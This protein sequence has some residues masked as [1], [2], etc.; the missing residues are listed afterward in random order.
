MCEPIDVSAPVVVAKNEE[1]RSDP[2]ARFLYENS[3]KT[4]PD[5]NLQNSALIFSAFR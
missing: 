5:K 2:K 4:G 1:R 3:W